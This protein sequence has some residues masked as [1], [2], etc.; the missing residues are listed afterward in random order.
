MPIMPPCS[1]WPSALRGHRL[2]AHLVG[3]LL[4]IDQF[5]SH[6]VCYPHQPGQAPKA[7]SYAKLVI[8]FILAKQLH[9]LGTKLPYHLQASD[10][11]LSCSCND[12]T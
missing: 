2:Q 9:W 4:P 10:L 8:R 12:S 3:A 5:T 1:Q 7:L 6:L 11:F